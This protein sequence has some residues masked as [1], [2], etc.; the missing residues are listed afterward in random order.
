M[1]ALQAINTRRSTRRFL[2]KEIDEEL[3]EQIIEAGRNAPTGGNSQTA[4]IIVITSRKLMEKLNTQAMESFS[5]MEIYEGMYRSKR[6]AIENSRKGILRFHYN[7][8]VLIVLA[9]RKDYSNSMADCSCIL[10]NMLIA[11]NA[12]DLGSC[13]VNQLHWLTDNPNIRELLGIGEDYTICNSLV[14]GY[15]DT[16]DGKPLRQKKTLKGNKVTYIR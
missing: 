7:A 2:P 16:E 11:A 4:E 13:Y 6:N 12:L 9:N 14:I 15:P 10:E 8:P 1:E 5:K 3:L